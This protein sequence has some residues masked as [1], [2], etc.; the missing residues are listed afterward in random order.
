MD[1]GVAAVLGAAVGVVGTTL[2]AA[3][4][5]IAAQRQ[6][7]AEHR[8][9]RRQLRRDAYAAFTA[10][11]DEAQRLLKSID[12]ELIRP[13]NDLDAI[14]AETDRL[15][16]ILDGSLAEAQAI[17][18]IEGPEELAHAAEELARSLS[19][20]VA[21]IQAHTIGRSSGTPVT[22][23]ESQQIRRYT[24]HMSAKRGQ[25]VDRARKAIDV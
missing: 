21:D 5:G 10:K 16:E 1:A 9:W 20:C 3:V 23:S 17:V 6:T 13:G 8:Q 14:R 11:A 24:D 4:A 15:R 22:Q 2:A 25:F 7:R 18:E 12:R 19:A